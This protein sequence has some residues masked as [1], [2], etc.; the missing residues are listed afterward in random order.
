MTNNLTFASVGGLGLWGDSWGGFLDGDENLP[1][2]LKDGLFHYFTKQDDG[3]FILTMT[4]TKDLNE[5][6]K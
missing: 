5:K 1:Y 3:S 2:V 6:E 4:S